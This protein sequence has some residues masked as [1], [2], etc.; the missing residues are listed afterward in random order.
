MRLE[1]YGDETDPDLVFVLGWGTKPE[2]EGVTWLLDR[3]R[4][5]GYHLHVFEIPTVVTDFE[6]EWLDPVADHVATLEA[7]RLL[8]HSTGG[9]IGEF[10]DD[11]APVTTVHL[12]PWWG[13]HEDLDNPVV[14]LAMKVPLPVPVL[15]AGIERAELGDLATE[16]QVEQLPDRSA[17]TFLREAKRAQERLPPFDPETA[18]FY[19]PTDG[20]VSAPAIEERAPP[21]NRV[22]YDGGH[23][24]FSSSARE[25]HLDTLLAAVDRGVAALEE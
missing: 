22:A 13:F 3:L 8:T 23:E 19:S 18:V 7:Y 10:L 25:D 6:A 11:P 4:E 1:R 9:L 24:F 12:S 2:F 14:D 17:P 5:A 20:V 15:P 16:A 21:A